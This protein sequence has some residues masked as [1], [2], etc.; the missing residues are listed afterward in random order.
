MLANNFTVPYFPFC[1]LTTSIQIIKIVLYLPTQ[2]LYSCNYVDIELHQNIRTMTQNNVYFFF[3]P[4]VPAQTSTS[5]QSSGLKFPAWAA[6]STSREA[7]GVP[8]P[9]ATG[10]L[11]IRGA[12]LVRCLPISS[13]GPH[14]VT[15]ST[16]IIAI[17]VM[18]Q[19]Y[20]VLVLDNYGYTCT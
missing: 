13:L 15:P 10:S 7:T 19:R 11:R 9:L 8:V 3:L 16:A 14:R 5:A 6:A 1:Y 4:T 17:C 12:V 20:C 2:S 18:K